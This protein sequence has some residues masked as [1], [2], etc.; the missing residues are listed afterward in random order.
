[1]S[2]RTKGFLLALLAAVIYGF[3]PILGKKFVTIFSPLF[4]AIVVIIVSDL[5]LIAVAFL[6]GELFRNILNKSARWVVVLGLFASLGSYF[7]FVG[8]THGKASAAGF[9]FQFE[10]FFAAIL[11]F[12]FLREKLSRYQIIG[13]VLMLGG[14]AIFSMPLTFNLGNLFFLAA[15][16]A[17]G[18]NGVITRSKVRELSPFFLA[19]GRNTFS[20]LFLSL[21]AYKYVGSNINLVTPVSG[22]FFLIYGLAIAGFL[23]SS[24][25]ALKFIKAGE[26]TSVQF[27]APLFTLL[28]AFVVLGERFTILQLFG[29]ALVL[30]GLYLI[31]KF[32]E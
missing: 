9:F 18:F 27:L 2:N 14:A 20:G 7:S 8:L 10:A 1:M 30:S 29:G 19:V 23:L 24:Y 32:K 22:F 31:V 4:A 6:K 21:V 12:V 15:A 16:L 28:V 17:W 26:A 3:I 25:S 5:Y 11:A 13:L